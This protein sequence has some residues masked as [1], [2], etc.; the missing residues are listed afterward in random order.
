MPA[1]PTLYASLRSFCPSSPGFALRL[2]LHQ[3]SHL[4]SCLRLAV[5]RVNVRRRLSLLSYRPCRAYIK[6][7]AD[8]KSAA[9]VIMTREPIRQEETLL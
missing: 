1:Y 2:P 6:K 5:R 8:L 7:A 9:F 4:R 3:G